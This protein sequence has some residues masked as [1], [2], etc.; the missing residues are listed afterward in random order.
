VSV[1]SCGTQQLSVM[2]P[3]CAAY[4]AGLSQQQGDVPVH[5]PTRSKLVRMSWLY[6]AI[7]IG[8]ARL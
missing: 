5:P 7:D 4:S 1:T 3:S 6:A 8:S 2:L